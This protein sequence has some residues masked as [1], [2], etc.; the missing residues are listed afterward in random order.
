MES[1]LAD[2]LC[3]HGNIKWQCRKCH[4]QNEAKRDAEIEKMRADAVEEAE[5]LAEN[6]NNIYEPRH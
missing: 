5:H 6:K 2:A 4:E 3:P 1:E